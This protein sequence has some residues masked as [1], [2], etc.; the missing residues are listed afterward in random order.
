M[1]LKSKILFG[2]RQYLAQQLSIVFGFL[3][4]LTNADCDELLAII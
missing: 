2:H 3:I 4:K 1:N